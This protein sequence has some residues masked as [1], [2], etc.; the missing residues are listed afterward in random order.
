MSDYLE[1]RKHI[2]KQFSK[3]VKED[4]SMSS[5]DPLNEMLTDLNS[6]YT[7][8][9]KHEHIK[10]IDK[11]FILNEED[12]I[13]IET[14][15]L[16]NTKTLGLFSPH[17]ER[18]PI[19]NSIF[20]KSLFHSTTTNTNSLFGQPIVPIKAETTSNSLF[21]QPLFPIEPKTIS[22]SF[23]NESLFPNDIKSSTF[24]T[25]DIEEY[26]D[27]PETEKEEEDIYE[28]EEKKEPLFKENIF[29]PF[30]TSSTQSL[31]QNPEEKLF[32]KEIKPFSFAS[33]KPE[34][35]PFSFTSSKSDSKPFSF[36]SSKPESKPFTFV[37]SKD[38]STPFTSLKSSKSSGY[39]P[40][41]F[42]K[43]F[44][45]IDQFNLFEGEYDDSESQKMLFSQF[46]KK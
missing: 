37:S 7:R 39:I 29:N 4:S 20:A 3:L 11:S 36:A 6:H 28:D 35:K 14:H 30:S 41:P 34:S 15:S 9:N 10:P 18:D 42:E 46:E 25:D 43:D 2:K 5:I 33:S 17:L 23:F 31:F 26:E 45:K 1:M 19:Q 44:G 22:R 21:G 32:T 40:N 16:F 27:P 12:I 24:T 8:T 38:E 13:P